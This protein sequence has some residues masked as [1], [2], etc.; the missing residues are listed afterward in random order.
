[1]GE[2]TARERDDDPDDGRAQ[3]RRHDAASEDEEE[4]DGSRR[5]GELPRFVQGTREW[6]RRAED[7]PD[8]RSARAVEKVTG[9][10]AR[11]QPVELRARERD[12]GSGLVSKPCC[13]RLA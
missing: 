11:P 7:R 8:R 1:M 12:R 13:G 3:E 2:W 9:A 10:R 4:H 5:H 6:D